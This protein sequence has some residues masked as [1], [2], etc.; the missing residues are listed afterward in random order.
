MKRF[1]Y[2]GHGTLIMEIKNII[3]K[4][5]TSDE[6]KE[7]NNEFPD[8]YLVNVF[9]MI[10]ANKA[11]AWQVGYYDAKT[12]K[13]TTFII[14]DHITRN[15][16][17]EV[18]KKEGVIEQLDLNRLN[19]DFNKALDIANKCQKE[20]HPG[21]APMKEILILQNIDVGQVY[22]ITFVTQSFKTLNIKVASDDGNIVEDKIH[23]IFEFD[24]KTD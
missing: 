4:L 20:K 1:L 11:D 9:S 15:P 12:D 6:F 14:T 23:S 22:N 19:I 10:S 13:I 5:E 18:F 3:S 7:F 24:K 21:N 17:S 16:H 2:M 8:A